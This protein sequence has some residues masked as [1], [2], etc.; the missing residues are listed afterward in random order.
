MIEP[1]TINRI[2][3]SGRSLVKAGEAE[4]SPQPVFMKG[5][6]KLPCG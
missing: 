6:I 3:S 5:G 1:P 4:K 2:L